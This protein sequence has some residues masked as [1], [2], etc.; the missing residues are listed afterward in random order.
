MRRPNEIVMNATATQTLELRITGEVNGKPLT[1]ATVSADMFITFVNESRDFLLGSKGSQAEREQ[2]LKGIHFSL[3][4]GSV[5]L[6]VG[7]PLLLATS[8]IATDLTKDIETLSSGSLDI[9]SKRAGVVQSMGQR[10]QR[11]ELS[12][13]N[14]QGENLGGKSLN[15]TIDKTAKFLQSQRPVWLNVEEYVRAV[16]T[17]MGGASSPNV[18]LRLE[19]GKPPVPVF[20][21]EAYLKSLDKNYLYKEVIAHITYK[22]NPRT[23]QND[24]YRLIEFVEQPP[25]LDLEAF[26]LA[27]EEGTKLWQDVPDHVAWVRDLRGAEV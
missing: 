21:T 11:D 25:V 24:D 17:D 5:K 19:D 14:I 13:F 1:P 3:Q 22:H 9:D 16:I 6:R 18:H 8:T 7:I 20:T 23:K 27:V 4:D 15:V 12:A 26:A 2:F 10:L